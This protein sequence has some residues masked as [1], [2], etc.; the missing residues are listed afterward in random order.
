MKIIT[1][2]TKY[3][4]LKKHE[5]QTESS[6]YYYVKIVNELMPERAVWMQGY[7]NH[8]GGVS[9]VGAPLSEE[10][11]KELEAELKE[12]LSTN[13]QGREQ[14]EHYDESQGRHFCYNLTRKSK[15]CVEMC[16]DYE[17]KKK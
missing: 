3:Y 9:T 12:A 6:D 2:K 15:I 4:L 16:E 17:P 8:M 10:L 11:S 1:V 7:I 14:C 5:I 13:S